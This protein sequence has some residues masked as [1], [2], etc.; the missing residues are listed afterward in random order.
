[1]DNLRHG[2]DLTSKPPAGV[3]AT[4]LIAENRSPMERL[5]AAAQE[6]RQDVACLREFLW[7]LNVHPDLPGFAQVCRHVQQIVSLLPKY[8]ETDVKE[9]RL[10]AWI[11]LLSWVS[12]DPK[13]LAKRIFPTK[14][15]NSKQHRE[16]YLRTKTPN[17]IL[18]SAATRYGLP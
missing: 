10:G 17:P 4:E 2:L 8:P 13:E 11:P 15:S 6:D 1:M 18:R 16:R 7:L 3:D 5:E 12:K 14:T 9:F